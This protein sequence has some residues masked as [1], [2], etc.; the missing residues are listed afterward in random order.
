MILS[1]KALGL[2]CQQLIALTLAPQ[3]TLHPSPFTPASLFH[4]R[5]LLHSQTNSKTKTETLRLQY[6]ATVEHDSAHRCVHNVVDAQPTEKRKQHQ[7]EQE[8]YERV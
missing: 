8:E 3:R 1:L 4:R 5:L 7:I 6:I 2:F